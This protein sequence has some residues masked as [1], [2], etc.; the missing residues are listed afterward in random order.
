MLSQYEKKEVIVKKLNIIQGLDSWYPYVC[1]P[2]VV[3]ENYCKIINRDNRCRLIVPSY[4]KRTDATVTKKFPFDIQRVASM[5]MPEQQRHALPKL[6]HRIKKI[7]NEDIDILH[8][9][10]PFNVGKYF[11]DMGKKY[12]IPTIVT[13]H[14][15]FY[16]EFMRITKSEG[17]SNML[18]NMIMSTF[19]NTDYV[20][21]VSNGAAETLR[22]YGFEGD[23]KVIRNGTD[24]TLP[25]NPTEMVT[26]I[27]QEYNLTNCPNILLFVGRI[28]QVKNLDLVLE[29]L[30]IVKQRGYDFK[31]LIVGDG[32][33]VPSLKIK[34][35]RLNISNNVIFTGIVKDRER[36]KGFYLASDL[37]VFPSIFD[38]ASLVPIEAATF[39][40]PTLLVK[41]SPT[42][43][44]IVDNYSGFAQADDK[45]L[46]ADKIIQII[47][48]KQNLQRVANN[49]H[50]YVYRTWEDTVEEVVESYREIICNHNK[51][52]VNSK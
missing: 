42:S 43:E 47:S 10:S 31:F 14:T 51:T 20:W 37:F 40:L 50:Q 28:V 19:D 4:G 29:A 6:D 23:I 34:A 2:N 39:S 36:L 3:V 26:K 18:L 24:M 44:I 1:G 33:A 22:E 48:D 5:P 17:I 21:T 49:C 41:D 25:S 32:E 46:W 45:Q 35:T 52:A 16:D 13:F 7:F 8:C 11:N 30:A 15:K 27:K 9:H 12:N 38:T